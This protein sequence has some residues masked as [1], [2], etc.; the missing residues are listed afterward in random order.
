MKTK[1]AP[2]GQPRSDGMGC[3]SATEWFYSRVPGFY[4]LRLKRDVGEVH[5]EHSVA[6]NGVDTVDLVPHLAAPCCWD[7]RCDCK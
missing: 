2:S 3:V 6:T 5:W 1:H 4:P 7:P